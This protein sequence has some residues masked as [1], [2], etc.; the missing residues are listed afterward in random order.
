MKNKMLTEKWGSK[1]KKKTTHTQIHIKNGKGGQLKRNQGN[2]RQEY[3]KREKK[4]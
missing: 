4:G 2:Q 3:E 1:K